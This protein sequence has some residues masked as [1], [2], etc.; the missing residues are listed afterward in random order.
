M[1]R[2]YWMWAFLPSGILFI[3][4]VIAY[5][6]SAKPIVE[7]TNTISTILICIPPVLL[8]TGLIYFTQ[9]ASWFWKNR[10]IFPNDIINKGLIRRKKLDK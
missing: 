3:L 5:L 6:F 8:M 1:A 4:F 2:K 9:R 7:K 10:Q